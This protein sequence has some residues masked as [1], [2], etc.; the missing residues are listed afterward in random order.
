MRSFGLIAAA[1]I[2]AV[3]ATALGNTAGGTKELG[4]TDKDRQQWK[5]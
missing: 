4:M 5:I 3:G 1:D 2:E